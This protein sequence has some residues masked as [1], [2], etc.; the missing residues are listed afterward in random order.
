[1]AVYTI[2]LSLLMMYILFVAGR[3]DFVMLSSMLDIGR[4]GGV[5]QVGL[6]LTIKY[7]VSGKRG[8]E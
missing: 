1:M 6:G 7:R 5:V 8:H 4:I 2:T 3:Q